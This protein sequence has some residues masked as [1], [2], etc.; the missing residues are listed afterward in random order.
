M[1]NLQEMRSQ[2]TPMEHLAM[3]LAAVTHD[4]G[5]P[6]EPSAH[7]AP[8]TFRAASGDARVIVVID[9]AL[10]SLTGSLLTVRLEQRLPRELKV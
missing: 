5:H 8:N 3:V 7:S 1:A 4:I 10:R 9:H 2:L 6:G